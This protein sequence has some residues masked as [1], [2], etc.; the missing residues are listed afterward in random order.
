MSSAP[1]VASP[2]LLS[3]DA[4]R[5]FDMMWI[6]GADAFGAALGRLFG[7]TS[8]NFF[9]HQLDHVD[10]AGFHFYDLIF[11]LFVFMVGAAVPLSLDKTVAAEGRGAALGRVLRRT[12]LLYVVGLFYYGGFSTPIHEFRL[13]GVLQRLALCYGAASL[14]YLYLRPRGLV[15]TIVALLAGYWALLTFFPVP[16]FGAGDFTEGH[17][18]TN[19]LDAHFLPFRKWDGDHDPEGMLSTFPAIA[20]CLLGVLASLWLKRPAQAPAARGWLLAG[21]GAVLVAL[22]YTWGLEFPLIK[23]LWTSSFVLVAGGWSCVLLAAF[24][25]I[26]DVWQLRAWAVPFSWIGCNPLAIYLIANVVDLDK[27]AAR[28][29]GGDIASA[30]NRMHD[31]LGWMLTALIATAF[32]FAIARFLYQRKI[33]LRL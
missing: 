30:L 19:W 26:I 13:L 10:W 3:L 23:K 18:L 15:A 25:L 27:L 2:R 16:G 31:G 1:A 28:F 7:G 5:G 22:G 29:A 6:V 20:S 33:F 17:N 8:G 14:L 12:A 9:A 21:A 11:P 32:S 24:Y 4:L